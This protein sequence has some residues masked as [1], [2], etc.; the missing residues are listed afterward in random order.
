M[1][2]EN[3]EI[4]LED[5]REKLDLVLEGHQSLRHD[6]KDMRQEMNER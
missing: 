4:L 3:L 5:M 6:I 2:K 1:G